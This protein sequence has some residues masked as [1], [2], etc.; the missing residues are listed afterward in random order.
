M[1]S[2]PAT[3]RW[4]PRPFVGRPITTS[5]PCRW[6][7]SISTIV[8][9]VQL[10]RA[11]ALSR[12]GSV[13]EAAHAYQDV[14]RS[15]DGEAAM[16]ARFQAMLSLI[17]GLDLEGSK[18][19]MREASREAGIELPLSTAAALRSI[20]WGRLA[21]RL[22]PPQLHRLRPAHQIPKP[23]R[24]RLEM[25][26]QTAECLTYTGGMTFLAVHIRYLRDA[27]RAG[28]PVHLSWAL[29]NEVTFRGYLAHRHGGTL[30][31][32]I[33]KATKAAE[34]S[35]TD[36]SRAYVQLSQAAVQF[37]RRE[38]LR[39]TADEILALAAVFDRYPEFSWNADVQR[40]IATDAY[41]LS[42]AFG[43]LGQILPSMLERAKDTGNE[44]LHDR[45][46]L[47]NGVVLHLA[48][49]R[50]ELARSALLDAR[51]PDTATPSFHTW[52]FD[53][54]KAEIDAYEDDWVG[55]SE[56]LFA[57]K[58]RYRG[59]LLLAPPVISNILWFRTAWSRT[60]AA[61]LRPEQ[62][63]EALRHVRTLIARIDRQRP[64]FPRWAA[65]QLALLRALVA[66]VEARRDD[67]IAHLR[68]AIPHFDHVQSPA[69]S[70]PIRLQLG[71]LL[72]GNE[73][74]ALQS[75]AHTWMKEEGVVDHQRF[76][77]WVCPIERCL[78]GHAQAS[79]HRRQR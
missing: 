25:M 43:I 70:M 64:A 11:D 17:R 53:I 10:A 50:P 23:V 41:V 38:R 34:A 16:R 61:A 48:H 45:A 29:A 69:H 72:G 68:D 26:R 65:G 52:L 33:A 28:D 7:R 62:R 13:H 5:A 12:A 4:R 24:L 44:F 22:R 47:R 71:Q 30:E 2:K 46:L 60:V 19:M 1:R 9:R 40:T 67:S 76:A 3:E 49:D 32:L 51:P 20:V 27:A 59:T 58:R 79:G 31:A 57:M 42:G 75:T 15:L 37:F 35:G 74:Q 18:T 73:G 77:R 56:H 66:A 39:D 78:P 21:L 6:A 8:P 36:S 55:A 63:D 14:A 54:R